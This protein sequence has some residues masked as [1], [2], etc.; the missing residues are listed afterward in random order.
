MTAYKADSHSYNRALGKWRE[1]RASVFYYKTDMGISD[2]EIG[3]FLKS[4]LTLDRSWDEEIRS[5]YAEVF[6]DRPLRIEQ[7]SS[8]GTFHRVFRVLTAPGEVSVLRAALIPDDLG[9]LL[10]AWA[11]QKLKS[12]GLPSLDVKVV[13]LS[14]SVASFDYEI[15]E[16]AKGSPLPNL[17]HS[18]QPNAGVAML[19]RAIAGVHAIR[20]ERFGPIDVGSLNEVHPTCMFQTW[21]EYVLLNLEQH[22]TACLEMGAVSEPEAENIHI[23]FETLA[24][25]LSDARSSLLHGD[26][27]HHNIFWDGERITAILDWE[28]A[29]GGDPAFDIAFWGT[30][31]PEEWLGEFLTGYRDLQPT[32]DH[33]ELRYWL[34]YLRVAL[35]KTVHRHRFGYVDVGGRASSR[36]QRAL[37]RLGSHAGVRKK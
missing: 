6:P 11:M 23:L 18:R 36:I 1:E 3:A 15:M 17:A 28:D 5:I 34:Y 2:E 37:G 14:R 22:V 19:G 29:L 20:M 8:Q 10:D 26:L 31:F 4:R 32:G 9:L 7:M 27:G 13:D 30:F 24:P 25:L 35:A 12:A 21:A 33:F 16:E